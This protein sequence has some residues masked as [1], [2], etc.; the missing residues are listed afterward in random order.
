MEE[1]RIPS[2]SER[3]KKKKKGG[4]FFSSKKEDDKTEAHS[5]ETAPKPAPAPVTGSE[6][7]FS[8]PEPTAVPGMKRRKPMKL[9]IAKPCRSMSLP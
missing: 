7:Y 1:Q 6:W 3:H 8:H 5:I 9:K 4:L 2:R